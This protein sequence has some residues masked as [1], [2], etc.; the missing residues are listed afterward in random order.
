LPRS[1][2]ELE[3]YRLV[4]RF[5]YPVTAAQFRTFVQNSRYKS[6][7]PWERYS[8]FDNHPVV[9]VTW[10]DALEYG[11]WLT[12]QLRQWQDT[13]EPL[14][15]LLRDNG[16]QVRLPTEAEWEKAARGN[17]GLI[18]PWGD[19]AEPEKANYGD[20]GIGTTSVVG[21]FPAGASP[22]D[23][24]DMSGNVWEWTHSLWGK[25]WEKSEFKYPYDPRDGRENE[26]ADKDARR[27][28]RGGS[29]FNPVRRLRCAHRG[30]FDPFDGIRFGGFRVVVAP[31][32]PSDL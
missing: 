1:E 19:N 8:R 16:W 12:G 26:S 23:V 18:F 4:L 9:A 28:L 10:Y 30:W 3:Q 17:G 14:K 29:F 2:A 27:V 25:D 6:Q 13:P 22:Y 11:R 15:G 21:C 24:Y 20:T 7:G 31:G 5:R 32:F